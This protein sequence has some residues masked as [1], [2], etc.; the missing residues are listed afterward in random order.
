MSRLYE[1][2]VKTI[3]YDSELSKYIYD[4]TEF[5]PGLLRCLDTFLLSTENNTLK[6]DIC[7][8]KSWQKIVERNT[9]FLRELVVKTTLQREMALYDALLTV[10]MY[11]MLDGYINSGMLCDKL[12]DEIGENAIEV[13]SAWSKSN[14]CSYYYGDESIYSATRTGYEKD[15]FDI[16]QI[17]KKVSTHYQNDLFP[18][19]ER[20]SGACGIACYSPKYY[21]SLKEKYASYYKLQPAV[22]IVLYGGFVFDVKKGLL[23]KIDSPSQNL[24]KQC[25][26]HV[27]YYMLSQ[28]MYELERLIVHGYLNS[29]SFKERLDTLYARRE[30]KELIGTLH[31]ELTHHCNLNC[32]H[33]FNRTAVRG[34]NIDHQ[35]WL[36]IIDQFAKFGKFYTILFGGEPTLYDEIEGILQKLVNCG[37]P[38]ELF[39]NATLID[40]QYAQMLDKYHLSRIKVSLDGD[41]SLRGDSF[42]KAL[43]GIDALK[44]N[45]NAPVF[46]NVTVC[47]ENVAEIEA[48]VRICKEHK[49]DGIGFAPMQQIGNAALNSLRE[50]TVDEELDVTHFISE[51]GKKYDIDVG[52]DRFCEGP[53]GIFRESKDDMYTRATPCDIGIAMYYVRSD[54]RLSYCPDMTNDVFSTNLNA[55]NIEKAGCTGIE[56]LRYPT[57]I[58]STCTL[59]YLCMGSCKASIYR[60]YDTFEACD[61]DQKLRI[62]KTLDRLIEKYGDKYVQ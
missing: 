12:V 34:K 13:M 46:V 60:E 21:E 10:G 3:P 1:K 40:D 58:C 33:C 54:G 2:I 19:F 31:L 38:V 42:T 57:R 56:N 11:S 17:Q 36:S 29:W 39:T 26:E 37:F 14:R 7:L 28:S 35:E 49:V 15:Y 6:Q 24:L 8:L 22:G 25:F 9:T 18:V 41:N 16:I 59:F 45:T 5:H 62:E 48:I 53:A 51:L 52:M 47:G 43:S 32:R 55:E 20:L 27:P 23:I 30:S 50:I 44:R 4:L 61:L